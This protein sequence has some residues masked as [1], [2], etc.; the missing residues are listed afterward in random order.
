M[1]EKSINSLKF[2]LILKAN[3]VAISDTLVFRL[4]WILSTGR[5]KLV[6]FFYVT[7]QPC[8]VVKVRT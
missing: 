6:R 8:C 5:K 2:L 1:K 3:L 4:S 7:L